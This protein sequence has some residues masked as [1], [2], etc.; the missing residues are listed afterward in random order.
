MSLE[1]AKRWRGEEYV[2]VCL[3]GIPKGGIFHVANSGTVYTVIGLTNPDLLKVYHTRDATSHEVGMACDLLVD[4]VLA[5]Q[6]MIASF[7]EEE[8]KVLTVK[9]CTNTLREAR[10]EAKK[11][12][13]CKVPR[14]LSK[15]DSG[16]KPACLV[17]FGDPDDTNMHPAPD[18]LL[19]VLRAANIFGLM[20]G[21]KMLASGETDDSDVS[22]GDIIEEEAFLEAREESL[23]PKTRDDLARGLGQPNGYF[24]SI[25]EPD[26]FS[27]LT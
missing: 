1:D 15:S 17:T 16:R 8:L 12:N 2:A 13:N 24:A 11:N 23:R 4:A 18:P 19:L 26:C 9:R 5:L 14:L 27:V 3:A 6:D 22:I 21:M 20:A 10:D 25:V 7:S